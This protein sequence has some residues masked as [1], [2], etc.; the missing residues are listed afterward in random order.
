MK[1]AFRRYKASFK[2]MPGSAM[3]GA[4][5]YAVCTSPQESTRRSSCLRVDQR[6]LGRMRVL[7]AFI[8]EG[9][10]TPRALT[11]ADAQ[12]ELEF[13]VLTG[14]DDHVAVEVFGTRGAGLAR[15]VRRP[16]EEPSFLF[17]MVASHA[18]PCS[19]QPRRGHERQDFPGATIAYPNRIEARAPL[20]A[21]EA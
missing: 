7:N 2:P 15:Y 16:Y 1:P 9:S 11:A 17:F 14:P 12:E 10:I 21:R 6:D 3:R 8:Q 19:G 5:T 13:A 18:S 4:F 20:H